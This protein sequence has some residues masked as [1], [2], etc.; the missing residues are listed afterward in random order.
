M[1]N[2]QPLPEVVYA[3]FSKGID[4]ASVQ[5][6][7]ENL[8][9]ATQDGVKEAHIFFQSWGG[10]VQDGIA[11]YNLLK[12]CPFDVTLYNPGL[13]SS[14]AVI[15]YLGAKTRKTSANAMFMI[16]RTSFT[17]QTATSGQLHNLAEAAGL[18]DAVTEAILRA[19]IK[20]PIDRWD[21]MKN[22]DLYLT[23][24][25]AVEYK[26]ADGIGDFSPPLGAKIF[27]L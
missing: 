27:S 3:V 16:H 4:T 17:P 7:G 18:G 1:L 11:L 6:F 9:I 8:A 13:I 15:T 2:R 10:N 5:S 14:I 23:A 19:H 26:I 12:V 20:M 24:Q 22:Y 21:H 25:Q